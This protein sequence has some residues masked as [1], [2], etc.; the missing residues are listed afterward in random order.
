MTLYELGGG[1]IFLSLLLPVYV[2]LTHTAFRIPGIKDSFWLLLL[3]WICTVLAF[4]LS[5]SALQKI[6]AFTVNLTYNLEPI[7]GI[8]LAFL[9]FREDQSFG[10][11]FFL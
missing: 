8:A 6:S 2:T 3:S 5:M 7:Y 9:W 11:C 10:S 1:L 4:R